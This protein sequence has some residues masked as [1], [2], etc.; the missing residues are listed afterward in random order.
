MPVNSWT[1]V[2]LPAAD[3][4][5]SIREEKDQSPGEAINKNLVLIRLAKVT[6]D[7]MLPLTAHQSKAT[8]PTAATTCGF[9]GQVF[10]V[11]VPG[12]PVNLQRV[13]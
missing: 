4:K 5:L 1:T 8:P 7:V 3:W 6:V 9:W 10:G 11:D 13:H 12:C 2:A